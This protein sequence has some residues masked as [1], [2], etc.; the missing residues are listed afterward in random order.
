LSEGLEEY[1]GFSVLVE[2]FV[3]PVAEAH[4]IWE[5]ASKV[6]GVSAFLASLSHEYKGYVFGV[7]HCLEPDF[8]SKTGEQNQGTSPHTSSK[9]KR[10]LTYI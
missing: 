7:I 10:E 8:S 2:D 9:R 3:F 5:G 1:A 4:M 6:E